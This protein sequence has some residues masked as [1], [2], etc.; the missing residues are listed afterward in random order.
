MRKNIDG[1]VLRLLVQP[2]ATM[3][4]VRV[5][6]LSSSSEMRCNYGHIYDATSCQ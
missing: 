2:T 6:L 5:L 1:C 4:V 3:L